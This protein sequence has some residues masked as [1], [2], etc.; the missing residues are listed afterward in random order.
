LTTAVQELPD[1]TRTVSPGTQVRDLA[2][3]TVTGATSP[4]DATG[5]VEF[6]LCGPD[7]VANPDCSTGGTPAGSGKTL[8]DISS[9]ANANDGISGAYSDYVNTAANPLAPGFYCFRAVATLTN[10]DSPPA[11]T[12]TTNECFLVRD[13]TTTTTAQDWLPNDTATVLLSGGGPASGSVTFSLYETNNCTGPVKATFGPINLVN[14]QART[15]NVSTYVNSTTISWRV[16]FISNQPN[17]DGSTSRCEVSSVTID[18]FGV[19]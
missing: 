16:T 12:D 10:Y 8:V 13:V 1:S 17:V 19:P 3:I 2:T 15:N 5:T 18:N 7:A 4:Q 9:P 14:G 11:Y 6:F